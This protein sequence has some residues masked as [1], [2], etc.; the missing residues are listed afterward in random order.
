MTNNEET[1]RCWIQEHQGATDC[2]WGQW[3][4]WSKCSKDCGTGTQTRTRATIEQA[5]LGGEPCEG[6]GE[7][8]IECTEN[9]CENCGCNKEGSEY[10]KCNPNQNVCV[11]KDNVTGKYCDKCLKINRGF[12]NCA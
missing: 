8:E 6:E 10:I 1:K 9:N 7:E 2:K 5:K 3:S 11:C 4:P 12:P